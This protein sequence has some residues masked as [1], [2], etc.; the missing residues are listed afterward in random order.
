MNRIDDGIEHL[1]DELDEDEDIA[2]DADGTP[3]RP[4]ELESYTF[5][6]KTVDG[7]GEMIDYTM[8]TRPKAFMPCCT[9]SMSHH[10]H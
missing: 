5:V 10:V 8:R 3:L 7:F 2:Y 6:L 4:G 1:L 9:A